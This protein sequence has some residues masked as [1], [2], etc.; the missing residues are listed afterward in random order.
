VQVVVVLIDLAQSVTDLEV[1][2]K[3]IH[4]MALG[5]VDWHTAI[6]A[7]EVRM[8]RGQVCIIGGFSGFGV[9]RRDGR[10]GLLVARMGAEGILLDKLGALA[11]CRRGRVR[12]GVEQVVRSQDGPRVDGGP[13]C[14]VSCPLGEGRR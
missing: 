8:G 3:V 5:A 4:P 9:V 13:G 7:L 12:E 10:A 11:N 2:L 6:G 14:R 1:S